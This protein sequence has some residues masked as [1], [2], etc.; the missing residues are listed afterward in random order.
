MSSTPGQGRPSREGN[1]KPLQYS[2]LEYPMNRGAW[3]ATVTRV[4]KSQTQLNNWAC[5]HAH[6]HI[7]KFSVNGHIFPV[8]RLIGYL[9]E[10]LIMLKDS[11][12]KDYPYG[13]WIMMKDGFK[14]KILFGVSNKS[15][16]RS[17]SK[18]W[19]KLL[20]LAGML[21]QEDVAPTNISIPTCFS[22]NI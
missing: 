6:T 5:T 9:E 8:F 16:L 19:V 2:C 15:L 7:H 10:T 1:G 21:P 18:R 12:H 20:Y 11:S 17:E 14:V 4:A 22:F 13:V 3:W